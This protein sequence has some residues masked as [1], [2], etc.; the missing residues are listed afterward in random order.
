MVKTT[1]TY[2]GGLR[3]TTHHGLSGAEF[4]TDAPVDNNGKGESFSPTDL[5]GV[6]L[7]SCILTVMGIV[8]D[9]MDVDLTGATADVEK[10]MVTDPI[11]RI[12]KLDVR[13]TLPGGI[14]DKHRKKLERAARTCPVH[15][16]LHPEIDAPIEFG[17]GG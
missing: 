17:W 5:V 8:A 12:G 2:E 1:I 14:S 9:R 3:T 16:S 4:Q 13:L 6:A 7:G 10:T 11:R 15:K